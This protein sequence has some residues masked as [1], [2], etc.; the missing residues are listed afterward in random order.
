MKV[1]AYDLLVG[2][3]PTE[4]WPRRPK[5][6]RAAGWLERAQV[7]ITGVCDET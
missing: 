6:N 7:L 4:I 5:A 2:G 1:N 3:L